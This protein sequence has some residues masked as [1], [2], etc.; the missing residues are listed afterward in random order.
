MRFGLL[1]PGQG[2]QSPGMGRALHDAFPEAREVFAAADEALGEPI[3]RICFEGTAEELA[4]TE[5]TQ[6]AILTTSIAALRVLEA[7]GLPRPAAAAGHSLGE[8]SAHVAA[9]T[10]GFPDAV[11]TVRAR[12]R[13][14]QEAVPVGVGTMAAVLGLEADVV[15][16]VCREAAEGRIVSAA[17]LNSP[18][19]IVIAGHVDAVERACALASARGARKAVPLPVSAPFHCA[20][21]EPAATR[22]REVLESLTFE[23]PR[24]P[25][26]ANAN[27]AAVGSGVRARELLVDQVASPVRWIEVVEG[28]IADGI[29]TFLEVGPGKVLAG[30]VRRIDRRATVVSVADPDGVGP[31]LERLREGS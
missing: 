20:L 30:L 4:L 11:S 3:S 10:I 7:A 31:A 1:F 16:E 22:L 25:V 27:G 19:Q 6:P 21:M 14:M 28:M 13:F 5:N 17:N 15:D 23:D 2:A 26:H 29:E 12:G 18:G 8:Y 9:G 24:F